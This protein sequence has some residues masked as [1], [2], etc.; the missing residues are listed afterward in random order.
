MLYTVEP[1]DIDPGLGLHKEKVS[2]EIFLESFSN[3]GD[4]EDNIMDLP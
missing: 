2:L 3:L 4:R 1:R